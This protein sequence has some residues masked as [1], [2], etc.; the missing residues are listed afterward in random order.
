MSAESG[1]SPRAGLVCFAFGAAA[2]AAGGR[3]PDGQLSGRVL[4]SLLADLG[5]SESAARS[6]LLRMRQDGWLESV[7]NGRAARYRLAPAITAA[8]LRIDRQ[9]RGE[10]PAWTG[11]FSGVLHETPERARAFRDKLRRTAQLLGYATLRPGLLIA[12]SDRHADLAAL[13][14]ARPPG[15]QLLQVQLTLGA[16]ESRSVAARL[17][18][19]DTLAA[20]Y[21]EVLADARTMTGQA[22]R[23]AAGPAAFRAFA[24]ATLPIY[25]ATAADPDLPA[26]LLPAD[27]PGDELAW[28]LDEAFRGFGPLLG[29]YLASIATT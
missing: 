12:T 28:A 13:L 8:Q 23:H 11:S 27:W 10:R 3:L 6:S 4:L 5:V 17:W 2:G 29:G 20:R 21:R 16:A 26:E 18:H 22:G 7:R 19:L 25:E 14:P 15:S 24:A 9:L 1:L